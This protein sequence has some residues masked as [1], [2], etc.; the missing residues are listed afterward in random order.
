M[1]TYTCDKCGK[2]A[3]DKAGI[4][5]REFEYFGFQTLSNAYRF[6]N[7]VDVCG[8]CFERIERADADARIDAEKQRR[9]GFLARLGIAA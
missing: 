8:D 7:V 2:Q 4:V 9:R 3:H 6:G 1:K 5:G